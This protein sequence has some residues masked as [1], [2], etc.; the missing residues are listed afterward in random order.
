MND[1]SI[2]IISSP[3]QIEKKKTMSA[4]C[5]GLAE[6]ERKGKGVQILKQTAASKQRKKTIEA[7]PFE[8]VCGATYIRLRAIGYSAECFT[9][10][11]LNIELKRNTC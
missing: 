4:N 10:I 11:L 7:R 5:Q 2:G 8:H 9:H 3:H 6:S 1:A